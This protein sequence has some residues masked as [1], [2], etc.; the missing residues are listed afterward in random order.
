MRCDELEQRVQ[1]L[2][3]QRRHPDADL[4]IVRHTLQCR[5]CRRRVDAYLALCE[6]IDR[7]PARVAA[8]QLQRAVRA[9][10]DQGLRFDRSLRGPIGLAVTAA[11]VLVAV[12]LLVRWTGTRRGPLGQGPRDR[13]APPVA[14]ASATRGPWPDAGTLDAQQ[15]YR[16]MYQMTV[17]AVAR[18]PDA[19]LTAPSSE[20]RVARL[21]GGRRWIEPVTRSIR[22]LT[23]SVSAAL[24][25]LRRTL[26]GKP[27][28]AKPPETT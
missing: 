9:R 11:C 19:V 3:D 8:G 24:E 25:V 5:G 1:E 6:T 14:A 20:T 23:S 27:H 18:L 26:P 17:A 21:G 13:W 10:G 2:L 28:S 12:G 4:E 7:S 15:Q 22:P 16:A